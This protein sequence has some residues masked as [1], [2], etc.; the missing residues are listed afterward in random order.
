[1]YTPTAAADSTTT[2]TQHFRPPASLQGLLDPVAWKAGTAGSEGTPGAAMRLGLPD[3]SEFAALRHF[4]LNG[5]APTTAATPSRT[6]P[7][8]PTS[9]G[10]TRKPSRRP[11]SPPDHPSGPG[12]SYPAKVA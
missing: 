9:A 1:S 11:A 6:P 8:P 2:G 4:A 7:S 3:E 5:A 10:T 12:P